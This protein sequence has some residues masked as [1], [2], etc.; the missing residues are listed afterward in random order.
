[1]VEFSEGEG[2]CPTRLDLVRL[3]WHSCWT[4]CVF[5]FFSCWEVDGKNPCKI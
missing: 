2:V 4:V 1:M 5:F 3:T